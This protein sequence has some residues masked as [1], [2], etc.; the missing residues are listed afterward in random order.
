MKHNHC[1]ERPSN[2][3]SLIFCP[4]L[5]QIPLRRCNTL[6]SKIDFTCWNIKLSTLGIKFFSS[7]RKMHFKKLLGG[8]MPFW[9]YH[10]KV[11][12]FPPIWCKRKHWNWAT[13]LRKKVSL[14]FFLNWI[15]RCKEKLKNV[16]HVQPTNAHDPFHKWMVYEKAHIL[17]RYWYGSNA[18]YFVQIGPPQVEFWL[19]KVPRVNR[20][21]FYLVQIALQFCIRKPKSF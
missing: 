15:L 20:Y 4:L 11:K 7:L 1:W 8:Q 3:K 5:Y 21:E 6:M 14:N 18:F 9:V 17:T 16:G 19:C 13:T 10:C 2:V 12:S